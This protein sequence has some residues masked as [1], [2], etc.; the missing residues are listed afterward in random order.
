MTLYSSYKNQLKLSQELIG[1]RISK[2]YYFLEN[3]DI[4]SLSEQKNNFGHSLLNGIDLEIDNKIY[5]IGNG[6]SKDDH[7]GLEIRKT[8]TSDFE[9]IEET[10]NPIEVHWEIKGYKI[11]NVKIYWKKIPWQNSVGFYPQDIEIITSNGEVVFSSLE[12]N[13]GEADIDFTDEL[14]IIQNSTNAQILHLGKY[15]LEK[16]KR[17]CNNLSQLINIKE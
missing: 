13:K 8:K 1:K 16:E 7:Y 11:E 2:V 4:E 9:F 10:K 3:E 12:I 14:L 15:G 6:F 17:Y 5:S